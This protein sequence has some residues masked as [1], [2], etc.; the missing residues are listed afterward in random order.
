MST[1]PSQIDRTT[2]AR[3]LDTYE[4]P[5]IAK[6]SWESTAMRL[7]V[8]FRKDFGTTVDVSAA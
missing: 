8:G 7:R 1:A 3:V 5:L 2:A 6:L 4:S